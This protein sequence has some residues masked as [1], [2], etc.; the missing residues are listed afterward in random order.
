MRRELDQM[1]GEIPHRHLAIQWDAPAEV[2]TLLE[3]RVPELTKLV[4]P[5]AVVAALA[6]MIDCVP[7]D[8]EVGAHFCYGDSEHKHIVEPRDTQTMVWFANALA[9]KAAR[10][11]DWIHMPV[12]S[13]R[14]DDA[15]YA[16]LR[17]LHLRPETELYLGLVHFGDGLDGARRRMAA[18]GRAYPDFGLATECGLGRRPPETIEPLLEIHRLAAEGRDAHER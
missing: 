18:A 3:D 11:L 7:T 9:A 12:P 5:D 14:Y 13:A 10:A 8:V 2:H 17:N 1:F 6:H 4:A 15:Y 16:P